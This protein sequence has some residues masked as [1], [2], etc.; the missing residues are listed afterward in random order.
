M[1]GREGRAVL[2]GRLEV[3]VRETEQ[4]ITPT[5]HPVLR[6]DPM[7]TLMWPS[8]RP[9]GFIATFPARI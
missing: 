3:A 5:C 6:L 2:E 9:V 1:E 7:V 4:V 8:G